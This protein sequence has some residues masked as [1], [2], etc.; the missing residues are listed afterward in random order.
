M[1][2][3]AIKLGAGRNQKTTECPPALFEMADRLAREYVQR[4]FYSDRPMSEVFGT[5][6]LMGFMHA[7]Q[8]MDEVEKR[9]KAKEAAN[10]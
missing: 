1:R 3:T 4:A 9:A 5:I 6:Y 7:F 2:K 8:G 10:G